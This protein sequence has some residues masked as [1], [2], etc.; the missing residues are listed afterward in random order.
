MMFIPNNDALEAKCR[1]IFE[2]V[3]K[4]EDFKVS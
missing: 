1:E 3:A 2:A 4:A